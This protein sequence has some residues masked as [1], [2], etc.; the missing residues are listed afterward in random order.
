LKLNNMT[1]KTLKKIGKKTGV[2]KQAVWQKTEKGRAYRIKYQ[3][4]YYKKNKNKVLK[5]QKD[6]YH[7]KKLTKSIIIKK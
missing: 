2:S 1:E 6:Y 3:K 7:R 4:K 5:K